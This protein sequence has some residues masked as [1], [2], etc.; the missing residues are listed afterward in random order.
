MG[1]VSTCQKNCNTIDLRGA[2][3]NDKLLFSTS[4]ESTSEMNMIPISCTE[5]VLT[6]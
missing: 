3:V 4:L 2:Q 1:R 5:F 6:T